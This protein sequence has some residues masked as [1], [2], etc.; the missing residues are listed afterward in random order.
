MGEAMLPGAGGKRPLDRAARALET[1]GFE[2]H[3]TREGEVVLR[4]CP[5]ESL[6]ADRRELICGMNLALVQGL[7]DGLGLETVIARL[8]PREGMCCVALRSESHD[9]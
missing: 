7:I 4:N 2:P 8:A 1:C 5:F 9:E 6:R 3:R